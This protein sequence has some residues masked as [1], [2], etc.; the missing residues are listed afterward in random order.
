MRVS[1][2]QIKVPKHQYM[3]SFLLNNTTHTYTHAIVS[4]HHFIQNS[5]FH[6]LRQKYLPPPCDHKEQQLTPIACCKTSP[7]PD[8]F[9]YNICIKS[10]A[11]KGSVAAHHLLLDSGAQQP[12]GC[13]RENTFQ[14]EM[15]YLHCL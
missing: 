14:Q 2:T 3:L 7:Y 13:R 8:R 11:G 4:Y 12:G 1:C 6:S 15:R 9:I 5:L 10:S